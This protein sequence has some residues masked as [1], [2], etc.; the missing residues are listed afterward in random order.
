MRGYPYEVGNCGMGC[1]FRLTPCGGNHYRWS[2]SA[3][4]TQ[5]GSKEAVEAAAGNAHVATSAYRSIG[6]PVYYLLAL[7]F[8]IFSLS[9]LP[10]AA[11]MDSA[12]GSARQT[13]A[14]ATATA[15]A[16]VGVGAVAAGALIGTALCGSKRGS[17]EM[18]PSATSPPLYA[19]NKGLRR[20]SG[21]AQSQVVYVARESSPEQ[22]AFDTQEPSALETTLGTEQSDLM[23]D[24]HGDVYDDVEKEL[25]PRA[26]K[27]R[28]DDDA[29][30]DGELLL[31]VLVCMLHALY[32][33]RVLLIVICC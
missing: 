29:A 9:L 24:V 18:A 23:G 8:L 31:R 22:H 28:L 10:G 1:G 11:A 25:S 3:K 20:R 26:A 15:L 4:K 12:G 30:A 21:D 17:K 6:T 16:Q 13:A 27:M 2:S 5:A 19:S 33:H 32:T 14:A 7:I